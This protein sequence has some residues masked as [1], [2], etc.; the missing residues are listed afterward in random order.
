[1][2]I[3]WVC[4]DDACAFMASACFFITV[5]SAFM[6]RFSVGNSSY[7]GEVFHILNLQNITGIAKFFPY[8]LRLLIHSFFPGCICT[9]GRPL[10]RCLPSTIPTHPNVL[11]VN[12]NLDGG[13]YGD[14]NGPVLDVCSTTHSR[15]V[16]K[17]EVSLSGGFYLRICTHRR[18]WA[19]DLRFLHN[20]TG[21]WFPYAYH[22][23]VGSGR[24][25]GFHS[26][27]TC[28]F[29]NKGRT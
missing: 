21:R 8:F 23:D 16:V 24:Y 15:H 19:I 26:D 7:V 27:W 22:S 4:K 1:M 13:R 29:D 28:F 6:A 10:R 20:R 12:P 17:K 9:D 14:E 5:V 2:A 18:W 11:N 3:T 25:G